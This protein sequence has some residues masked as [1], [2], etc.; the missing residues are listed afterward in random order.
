MP[1][2]LIAHSSAASSKFEEIDPQKGM[3]SKKGHICEKILIT[4]YQD[5]PPSS[6]SE[7]KMKHQL[8]ESTHHKSIVNCQWYTIWHSSCHPVQSQL[9][10]PK[11]QSLREAIAAKTHP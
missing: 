6:N 7:M 2:D 8:Q 10:N 3:I 5:L 11:N 9:S 1:G 4:L